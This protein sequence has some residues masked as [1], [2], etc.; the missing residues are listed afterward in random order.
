[1]SHGIVKRDGRGHVR[2]FNNAKYQLMRRG[3]PANDA[4]ASAADSAN[5]S[6]STQTV[7]RVERCLWCRARCS[8]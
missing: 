1:M 8:V 2:Q 7:C 4:V 3:R 6:G 5:S